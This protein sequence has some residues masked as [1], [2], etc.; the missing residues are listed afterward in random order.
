MVRMLV[1]LSMMK[2]MNYGVENNLK[3]IPKLLFKAL[4]KAKSIN[5]KRNK[6]SFNNK[7]HSG[8]I[9]IIFRLIFKVA[10]DLQKMN[11]RN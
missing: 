1:L 11:Y 6:F 7:T 3:R 8:K 5:L 4:N 2:S 10:M 9:K